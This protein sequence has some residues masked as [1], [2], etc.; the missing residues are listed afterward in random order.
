MS[1]SIKT[2]AKEIW[3]RAVPKTPLP[4]EFFD[5]RGIADFN[6]TE[7]QQICRE[8][9]QTAYL[10]NDVVLCRVLTK[11]LV[12]ADAQDIGITPHFCLNGFWEMWITQLFAKTIQT[13]WNC[14]DIGANHGYFS[15]LMADLVGASGRVLAIEPNPKVSELL[16]LNL[17]VNGFQDFSTVVQ[18]AITDADDARLNLV[19]PQKR[20]LNA[21]ITAEKASSSD[22]AFEVETATLDQLT[23]NWERVDFVKIDAEGAEDSIWRGMRETVSKNPNITIVMEFNNSRYTNPRKFLEDIISAGFPLR[24]VGYDSQIVNLTLEQ[25]LTERFDEDWMLF[26]R[27]GDE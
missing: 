8:A 12:Y 2:T 5:I 1:N 17:E 22:D 9:C 19:F 7:V 24:H 4:K 16:A 13:G 25:C 15:L 6:R 20:A 26:L 27:R 23:K 10:G 21:I 14:V 11:Y 3:R 18:K